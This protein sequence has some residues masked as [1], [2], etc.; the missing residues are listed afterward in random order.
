HYLAQHGTPLIPDDL[1]KHICV[2]LM[3]L[4]NWVFKT[5]QGLKT[6]KTSNRLRTDNGEAVR[7]AAVSGMGITLTSVWCAYQQLQRG[8]LVQ[9]LQDHPLVNDT[10]IWAVYP[11]SRQIAPK[12]RTF[13]DHFAKYFGEAPYWEDGII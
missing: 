7:D 9:I 6:I 4:E 2:N 1:S 11:S 5:E 3:G 10:A 12:V 13:I 8:E